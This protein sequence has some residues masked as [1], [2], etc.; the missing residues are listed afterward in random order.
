[1]DAIKE[2]IEAIDEEVIKYF[3]SK[4]LSQ[5]MGEVMFIYRDRYGLTERAIDEALDKCVQEYRKKLLHKAFLKYEELLA[6]H[7]TATGGV[8]NVGEFGVEK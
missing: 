7:N 5:R 6:V 8:N 2:I 4:E 3:N 1:M